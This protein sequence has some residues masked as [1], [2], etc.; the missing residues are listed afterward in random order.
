[1]MCEMRINS[2][3]PALDREEKHQRGRKSC[4]YECEM[5]MEWQ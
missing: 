4:P 5:K 2:S 1:M 3:H